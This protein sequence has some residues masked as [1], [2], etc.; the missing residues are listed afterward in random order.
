MSDIIVRNLLP[1]QAEEAAELI[2][3]SFCNNPLFVKI[4]GSENPSH[5]QEALIRLY[6]KMIHIYLDKD[7]VYGALKD[8]VLSG[9]G[10]LIYPGNCK[11]GPAEKFQILHSLIIGN[12]AR[13]T[14]GALQWLRFWVRHDPPGAHWH[15]GPVTVEPE[16]Q[17]MGIGSLLFTEIC[18][19]VDEAKG[20]AFVEAGIP[21]SVLFYGRFGFRVCAEELVHNVPTWFLTR[22]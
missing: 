3:R 18:R 19:K 9:V 2:G 10:V 5:R 20:I 17:S 6:K 11:P 15:V 14:M 1:H 12:S 8:G 16:M 22:A 13:M 7:I 21:E 4:F